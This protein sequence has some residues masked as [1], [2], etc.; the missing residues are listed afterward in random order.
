MESA[1]VVMAESFSLPVQTREVICQQHKTCR[2]CVLWFRNNV[3]EAWDGVEKAESAKDVGVLW[4][5]GPHHKGRKCTQTIRS[6]MRMLNK[7]DKLA[8]TVF[9]ILAERRGN[10]SKGRKIRM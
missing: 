2:C 3:I 7:L 8:R 10:W 6:T 9:P 1:D 4:K 5:Q